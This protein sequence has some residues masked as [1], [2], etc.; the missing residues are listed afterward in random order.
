DDRT[1][2][3]QTPR[4]ELEDFSTGGA[5]QKYLAEA[6]TCLEHASRDFSSNGV[7]EGSTRRIG[8]IEIDQSARRVLGRLGEPRCLA[9]SRIADDQPHP[10]TRR[11]VGFM[12]LN[13]VGRRWEG[14]ILQL[15]D[16]LLEKA[17]KLAS[18]EGV[19]MVLVLAG[20][21]QRYETG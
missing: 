16:E 8:D 19:V 4:K 9:S 12:L 11:Q 6:V 20:G 18:L 3:G 21:C 1:L 7:G 5:R 17:G 2:L 10:L 13:A 14:Q 15:H